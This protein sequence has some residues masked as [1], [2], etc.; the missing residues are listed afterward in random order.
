MLVHENRARKTLSS[1]RIIDDKKIGVENKAPVMSHSHPYSDPMD[2][3]RY[4]PVDLLKERERRLARS[5]SVF[6]RLGD[7]ADSHQRKTPFL[8][9][10]KVG[11]HPRDPIYEPNYSYDDEGDEPT[12]SFEEDDD[13]ED[14]PFFHE[15][16]S[17]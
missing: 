16:R 17:T 10:R 2:S 7:E 15:I 1:G 14:L 8:D 12:R 4:Q 5:A 13:E 11:S 6:G 3:L 9:S